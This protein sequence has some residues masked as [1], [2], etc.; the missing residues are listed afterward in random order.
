VSNDA[1]RR[2]IDR[3]PLYGRGFAGGECRRG[4]SASLG[5]PVAGSQSARRSRVYAC[6]RSR[7]RWKRDAFTVLA[8]ALQRP[9]LAL[10]RARLL[11]AGSGA[12]STRHSEGRRQCAVS[13]PE[14][15]GRD[16]LLR[17]RTGPHLQRLALLAESH[18]LVGDQRL[19]VSAL[20]VVTRWQAVDRAGGGDRSSSASFLPR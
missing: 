3:D 15:H 17:V 7:R 12:S 19:R 18:H 8:H 9:S 4:G 2:Q 1:R 14:L 16:A 6:A 5:T 11:G 13:N 20:R 10:V